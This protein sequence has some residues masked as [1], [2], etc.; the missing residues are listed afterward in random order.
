[1][2]VA[3]AISL[4]A[5][6]AV[7]GLFVALQQPRETASKRAPVLVNLA[8][9]EIKPPLKTVERAPRPHREPPVLPQFIGYLTTGND[10]LFALSQAGPAE[11]SEWVKVG[12][13]FG[14]FQIV[15]F[16]TEKEV[17][18]LRGAGGDSFE[19]KVV[20]GRVVETEEQLRRRMRDLI[21][22]SP[23]AIRDLHTPVAAPRR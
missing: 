10:T 16:D 4:G 3:A 1:M 22:T 18:L 15:T 12:Q 13:Q 5:V 17:L 6:A 9:P 8:K 21:D 19:I 2:K 11:N 7:V 14:D 20:D 23:R